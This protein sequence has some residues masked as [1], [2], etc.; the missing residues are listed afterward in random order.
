MKYYACFWLIPYITHFKVLT[1]LS[2]KLAELD[3]EIVELPQ[4]SEYG[5]G[6]ISWHIAM[7]VPSEEVFAEAASI[8][9]EK[10]KLDN[11]YPIA[12]SL[13]LRG[14]TI[15]LR[16]MP[17]HWIMPF[18]DDLRDSGIHNSARQ[19]WYENPAKQNTFHACHWIIEDPIPA[20]LLHAV[21]KASELNCSLYSLNLKRK[22]G[23]ETI[24]FGIRLPKKISLKK[25]LKHTE[26]QSL[27]IGFIRIKEKEFYSGL[28]LSVAGENWITH[29]TADWH[30]KKMAQWN[31]EIETP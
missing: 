5:E 6:F 9:K 1:E 11:W 24:Y 27:F 4:P 22:D 28:R 2:D 25:F 12:Q 21:A 3:S 19:E 31:K 7:R 26:T 16:K 20:N 17:V 10:L 14:K 13:Y 15:D 18:Q 23:Y 8:A 29:I 30:L